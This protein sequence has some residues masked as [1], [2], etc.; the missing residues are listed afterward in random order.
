MKKNSPVFLI[1]IILLSISSC[2]VEKRHF[3]KGYH[4][5][6]HTAKKKGNTNP[7][8]V[9]TADAGLQK[10]S[11]EEGI[12]LH[13]EELN[14]VKTE[15]FSEQVAAPIEERSNQKDRTRIKEKRGV[16]FEKAKD[17]VFSAKVDLGTTAEPQDKS[18]KI[19]PGA[20]IGLA[21]LVLAFI[22]AF[23][24]PGLLALFLLAFLVSF[25]AHSDF[26]NGDTRRGRKLNSFV[27][28]A[29][30]VLAIL[31]VLALL[32]FLLFFTTLAAA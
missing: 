12:V 1:V 19:H 28:G 17:M 18:E 20:I 29:C 11:E 14:V 24:I 6:W 16:V 9:S 4:V 25:M 7:D 13:E 3:F 5:E 10:I 2:T 31:A 21:S 32:S 23:F 15:E 8:N 27:L 22:G 30:I 26:K